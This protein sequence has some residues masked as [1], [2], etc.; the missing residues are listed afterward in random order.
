MSVPASSIGIL[1]GTFD[2][3][4]N[5]HLAMARAALENL[6][7]EKLLFIPTGAP[8]YR[9]APVASAG[10]R[11]AMLRLALAGEP[12]YEI[13][14]RELAPEASAYTVDTLEALRKELPEGT[15]L[16][17]LMGADQYAKLGSWHR[18]HDIP[19]FADIAVFARPGVEVDKEKVKMIPMPPFAVSA[20]DIRAR[21]ARG[22]DVSDAVP[23]AVANYVARHRLY[24]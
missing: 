23:A 17:L 7:L 1:G 2:P 9:K 16:Y 5:A 14:E 4:H 15:M 12:R 10:D 8:R 3:V 11:V 13:D 6:A 18:P 22:E 21:A 24:S 19:R 20:S